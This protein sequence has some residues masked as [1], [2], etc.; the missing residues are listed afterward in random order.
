MKSNLDTNVRSTFL[1]LSSSLFNIVTE[2]YFR[3]GEGWFFLHKHSSISSH[4]NPDAVHRKYQVRWCGLAF[5]CCTPHTHTHVRS[6]LATLHICGAPPGLFHKNASRSFPD[7]ARVSR[8]FYLLSRVFVLCRISYFSVCV[9][10]CRKSVAVVTGQ[11]G[12]VNSWGLHENRR[13][14]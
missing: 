7:Q 12:L 3:F 11:M 4:A 8:W 9:C 5:W 6:L 14:S 1:F 13:L 2:K 10:V